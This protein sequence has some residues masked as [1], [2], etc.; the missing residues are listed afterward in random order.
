M[1]IWGFF[2]GSLIEET[3]IR[4]WYWMF[5]INTAKGCNNT[6]IHTQGGMSC[7][8]YE[9]THAYIVWMRRCL[10][11]A[12]HMWAHV[13]ICLHACSAQRIALGVI[14][15]QHPTCVLRQGISLA[16]EWVGCLTNKPRRSAWSLPPQ[17]RDYKFM[18]SHLD[19]ILNK[20]LRTELRSLYL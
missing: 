10:C 18:P 8:I 19:F 9:Y 5:H 6:M 2:H 4:H 17:C 14:Y 1:V 11:V 20:V 12:A 15:K 3:L 7:T 13:H 16:W